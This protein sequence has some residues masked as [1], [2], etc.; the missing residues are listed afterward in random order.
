MLFHKRITRKPQ[1]FVTWIDLMFCFQQTGEG[2]SPTQ[3]RRPSPCVTVVTSFNRNG[4]EWGSLLYSSGTEDTP[5]TPLFQHL[6]L[7][8]T[9]IELKFLLKFVL[10]TCAPSLH[11]LA[12]QQPDRSSPPHFLKMFYCIITELEGFSEVW[13]SH[14][15]IHLL[16][17]NHR[18]Y[19]VV[20]L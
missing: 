10:A 19:G 16:A 12:H 17:F 9:S 3:V 20:K 2:E 6:F 5:D 15:K 14:L 13:W 4:A 11:N 8:L 18:S 1:T 7:P